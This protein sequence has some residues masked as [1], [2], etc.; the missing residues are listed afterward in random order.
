MPFKD[1]EKKRE[2]HRDYMRERR[3]KGLTGELLN[4]ESETARFN[5]SLPHKLTMTKIG[6]VW[7][8]TLIQDGRIYDRDTGELLHIE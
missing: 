1:L 2:Y 8:R 4:P 7:R 3:R 6:G 5:P